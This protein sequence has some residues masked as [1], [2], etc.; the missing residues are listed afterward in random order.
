MSDTTV[1]A[2]EILV[3]DV[4][5]RLKKMS[6]VER[7]IYDSTLNHARFLRRLIDQ[8]TK[9]TDTEIVLLFR[10]V[11]NLGLSQ[12]ALASW[13]GVT[14]GTLSRWVSGENPPRDFIRRAVVQQLGE[15][16]NYVL[17]RLEGYGNR[18]AFKTQPS[19]SRRA[20]AEVIR[21]RG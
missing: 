13:F 20:R 19:G 5:L 21:L 15:V 7:A 18:P 17:E 16:V 2:S 10:Q 8:A 3:T 12:K 6:H 4:L 11:I 9:P 1:L 14:T